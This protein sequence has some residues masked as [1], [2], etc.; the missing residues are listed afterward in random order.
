[1]S[2]AKIKDSPAKIKTRA[3]N[4]YNWILILECHL[5][6]NKSPQLIRALHAKWSGQARPDRGLGWTVSTEGREDNRHRDN[7]KVWIKERNKG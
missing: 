3:L 4:K 2:L 1:M 5:G 6:E 7:D